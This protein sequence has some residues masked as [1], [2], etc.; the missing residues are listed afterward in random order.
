M[1]CTTILFGNVRVCRKGEGRLVIKE[2]IKLREI[3]KGDYFRKDDGVDKTRG[4][5]QHMGMRNSGGKRHVQTFSTAESSQ[6]HS[7]SRRMFLGI[8]QVII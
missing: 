5:Q 3:G 8:Y 6:Y 7:N 2:K 1:A 4:K